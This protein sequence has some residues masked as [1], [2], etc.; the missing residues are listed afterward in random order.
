MSSPVHARLR[1]RLP[2]SPCLKGSGQSK[3]LGVES[4]WRPPGGG[5]TCT[6]LSGTQR[7]VGEPGDLAPGSSGDRGGDL[8][9]QCRTTGCWRQRGQEIEARLA[10]P[11][12]GEVA[13]NETERRPLP[14]RRI[15]SQCRRRCALDPAP[16]LPALPV[17]PPQPSSALAPSLARALAQVISRTHQAGEALCLLTG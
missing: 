3:T 5:G 2:S 8:G 13:V 12:W 4:S 16:L 11:G 10:L 15:Q 6:C 9:R 7:T 17:Q 1:A 14:A